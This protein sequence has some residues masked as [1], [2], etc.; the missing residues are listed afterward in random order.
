[1]SAVYT[2][3]GDSIVTL[4][5]WGVAPDTTYGVHA[6]VTRAEPR[7][8]PQPTLPERCGPG[9]ALGRR[10]Y[11][12][13]TNEIRLDLTTDAEGIGVAQTRVPWQF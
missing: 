11:A 9:G 5:V 8:P 4:H 7:A 2:R 6:H 12:N 13:P 3:A 1:M 10:A